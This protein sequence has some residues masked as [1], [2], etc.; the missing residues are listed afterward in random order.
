MNFCFIEIKLNKR[1][2]HRYNLQRPVFKDSGMTFISIH[3]GKCEWMSGSV[4]TPMI[5]LLS[6]QLWVGTQYCPHRWKQR[7][8]ILSCGGNIFQRSNSFFFTRCLIFL[9]WKEMPNFGLFEEGCVAELPQA[10]QRPLA[11]P[12]VYNAATSLPRSAM[13]YIY[14]SFA[15]CFAI[16]ECA[17]V[18]SVDSC[19][20]Q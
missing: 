16:G 4:K 18:C 7:W 15:V 1:R 6:P 13:Q 17:I 11:Q 9:I 20:V 5:A 14:H 10:A 19:W 2:V 3:P 12:H 8:L